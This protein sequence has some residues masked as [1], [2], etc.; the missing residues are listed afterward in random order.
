MRIT[1]I[2]FAC[3]GAWTS[4]SL[5]FGPGLNLVVGSNEAGKSTALRAIEALLFPVK[6]KGPHGLDEL[7]RPLP[8]GSFDA[9][10]HAARGEGE[11]LERIAW[12]RCRT[13]VV[14]LEGRPLAP[15]VM[16]SWLWDISQQD[17][18]LVYALGHDR[19]R[20]GGKLL[21]QDGAV[22][23]IIADL[24]GGVR[25]L[26]ELRRT[27]TAARDDQYKASSNAKVPRLNN[28]MSALRALNDD[29]RKR[30]EV[31]QHERFLSL[32]D[33]QEREATTA[34]LR[35]E[36]LG[37]LETRIRALV[38]L[39]FA[40]PFLADVAAAV[41]ERDA[42]A[43]RTPM[44]P[45]TWFDEVRAQQT[46]VGRAHLAVR[47]AEQSV[48]RTEAALE[49]RTP[50]EPVLAAVEAIGAARAWSKHF[51]GFEGARVD[52]RTHRE[53]SLDAL[54]TILRDIGVSAPTDEVL[55]ASV[56]FQ[57]EPARRRTLVGAL[58][59]VRAA[60]QRVLTATT[61]LAK[62]ETALAER[63][64][65]LTELPES[66][67]IEPLLDAQELGK[68]HDAEGR[69][70]QLRQGA[71]AT[72]ER[73]Q[74]AAARLGFPADRTLEACVATPVPA[75]VATVALET[76]RAQV[77][78]RRALVAANLDA[79]RSR[80]REAGDELRDAERLLDPTLK[81]EAL[82]RL[83]AERDLLVERLSRGDSGGSAD[84]LRTL[85]DAMRAIDALVDRLLDHARM[86]ADR[87]ARARELAAANEAL[88][89]LEADA[90]A[91]LDE[92]GRIEERW[93]ALWSAAGLT[94]AIGDVRWRDDH[95]KF[96]SDVDAWR[97]AELAVGESERAIGELRAAI[98]RALGGIDPALAGRA[99]DRRLA[100]AVSDARRAAQARA[101]AESLLRESGKRRDKARREADEAN[102]RRDEVEA[103][104]TR[105]VA[106]AP[107]LVHGD[108]ERVEAW[109]VRLEGLDRAAVALRDAIAL[110]QRLRETDAQAR[111]AIDQ[112]FARLAE[113]DAAPPTRPGASPLELLEALGASLDEAKVTHEREQASAAARRALSGAERALHG[114][115]EALATLLNE[116]HEEPVAPAWLDTNAAIARLAR[117]YELDAEIADR[118]A[119]ATRGRRFG[120]DELVAR[121][122]GRDG[123]ALEREVEQ[124]EARKATVAQEL[125]AARAR[126]GDAQRRL[127]ELRNGASV[128]E[129]SQQIEQQ[130]ART[131]EELEEALSLYGAAALLDQVEEQL[132][133][134]ARLTDLLAAATLHFA[135]MTRGSFSA[136]EFK[137]AQRKE[138]MVVRAGSET[139]LEP[140]ALSDG[141]RDQLWLSL[142]LAL[143]EPHLS[144]KRLPLILDDILVHFDPARTVAALEALA[145]I[146]KH[147][148][149]ILFSHHPHVIELARQAG[150]AFEAIELPDR[151]ARGEVPPREA[152]SPSVPR[153]RPIVARPRRDDDAPEPAGRVSG[154]RAVGAADLTPDAQA[155]LQAL[156]DK[157][158]QKSGNKMLRTELGWDDARY[159]QV[160]AWL[161]ER[162]LV[163]VG[164]GRGGSV[165]LA[166]A[167]AAQEAEG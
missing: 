78:K 50:A 112:A 19:L 28:A 160:K 144:A 147:T 132:S 165:R 140:P 13:V 38:E 103:E 18:R 88:Q 54:V 93:R 52:A 31:Q 120:W 149:V 10:L 95:A 106:D 53:Q 134:D 72:A 109:I 49:G 32:L 69:L 158:E 17:Y 129:V 60:R 130:R 45:R 145:E 80:Q 155:F 77:D 2:D 44:P 113:R 148:Q 74:R 123:L 65:A 36:E 33:A 116:A 94:V 83:R 5:S 85:F 59:A 56:T 64:E 81:R 167:G 122:D 11:R 137:D 15:E 43:T 26:P 102:R 104:L 1:K 25:G 86:V 131:L 153:P 37:E 29:L 107:A 82:A 157:P 91:L 3:V 42:S 108:A 71:A 40:P 164:T 90:R 16:S 89:L 23:N 111:T 24:T 7:A 46:N 133:E 136:V 8:G 30:V 128:A 22:A 35:G 117:W 55:G 61:A 150:L 142:R 152:L 62:E 92:G 135:R 100:D 21:E 68:A 110:D 119:T 14:D 99:I 57:I 125:D 48:E 47:D 39:K 73:L 96:V 166:A 41:A 4:R 121:V 97:T 162:K 159:D 20:E 58:D 141:T 51:E 87:D 127:D 143:I 101:E 154:V 12:R 27:L 6:L 163:T 66:Q 79:A 151:E 75:S 161:V 126:A 63:A 105:L 118:K 70:A 139:R 34:R 9:T 76:E 156:A 84:A 114:A 98:G 146:A 124:L 67:P 138:L 115:L